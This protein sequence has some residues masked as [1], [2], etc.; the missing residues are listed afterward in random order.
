MG[1][2]ASSDGNAVGFP[3]V[4]QVDEERGGA[5]VSI[6]ARIETVKK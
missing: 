4:N 5:W 1:P 2:S 3:R 6:S